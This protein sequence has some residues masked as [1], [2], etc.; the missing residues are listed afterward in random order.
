ML[1]TFCNKELAMERI[2]I[3]FIDS[4]EE[5]R[6]Q[7]DDFDINEAH[8]FD[9]NEEYKL[10]YIMLEI[11]GKKKFD[12]LLNCLKKLLDEK[13]RLKSRISNTSIIYNQLNVLHA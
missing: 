3:L 1:F 6:A 4:I 5:L 12:T 8:C 2:E 7:L 11:I 9:P 10:R 13:D